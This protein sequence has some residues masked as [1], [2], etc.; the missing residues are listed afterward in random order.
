M[1]KKNLDI[2]T[3]R[4]YALLATRW[5][6]ENM[7]INK[8]RKDLPKVSVRINFVKEETERFIS[9]VFYAQ[10]NKIIVYDKNCDSIEDVVSTVIHEYTH[11]L[12]SDVKYV[13][14]YK[15]YYYKNH[16]Y[17]KEARKN[18][19]LYTHLCIKKIKPLI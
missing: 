18:E 14:L 7:G 6:R 8:R 19:E 16:P 4:R 17:E 2:K 10:Q 13:E 15:K 3:K 1:A 9:G 11:Y 12:Q 5:C